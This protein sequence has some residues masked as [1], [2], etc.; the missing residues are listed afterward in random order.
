MA[1]WREDNRRMANGDKVTRLAGLALRR[2]PSVDFAGYW[3]RAGLDA[4]K[5][6]ACNELTLHVMNAKAL[7]PATRF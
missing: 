7:I 4:G 3:Q 6:G 5:L 1:S 2:K